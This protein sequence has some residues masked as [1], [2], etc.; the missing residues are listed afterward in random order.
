MTHD[1]LSCMQHKFT[2]ESS[3]AEKDCQQH[4]VRLTPDVLM[5]ALFVTSSEDLNDKHENVLIY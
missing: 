3:C 1:K 2:I 4:F 5:G